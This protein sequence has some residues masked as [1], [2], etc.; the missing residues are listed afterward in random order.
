MYCKSIALFA[1]LLGLLFIPVSAA[2]ATSVD[3]TALCN[4]EGFPGE[5]IEQEITLEGTGPEERSG[6]WH[7]YYKETEGDDDRMDITSWITFEPE[8]YTIK[9]GEI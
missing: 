2:L 6:F 4:L 5:T 8:D 7:T 9:Q 1:L 3:R